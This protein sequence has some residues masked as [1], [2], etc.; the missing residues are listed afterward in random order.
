MSGAVL[1]GVTRDGKVFLGSSPVQP[2]Q[3]PQL[4]GDALATELDKTVYLKAD[5]RATYGRVVEVVD[6]V[7]SAGVDNLGLITERLR[8]RTSGPESGL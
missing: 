5:A 8:D 6:Q 7:R 4:V 2:E 3:L 1:I